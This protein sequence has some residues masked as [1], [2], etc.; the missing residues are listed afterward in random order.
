MD[1]LTENQIQKLQ[2]ALA[3][4]SAQMT[5]IDE[6]KGYINDVLANVEEEIGIPKKFTRKLAKVY[7]AK[8]FLEAQSDNDNFQLLLEVIR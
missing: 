2:S 8:E 6:H 7:H 5:I 4:M 1:H 3:D